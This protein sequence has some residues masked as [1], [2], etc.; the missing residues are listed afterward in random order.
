MNPQPAGEAI[1]TDG[2]AVTSP[3]SSWNHDRCGRCG[4]TFRRG[5]A[6]VVTVRPRLVVVHTDPWLACGGDSDAHGSPDHD[7]AGFAAGLLN[8][9]PPAGGIPV[10]RLAANDWRVATPDRVDPPRCLYCGHTFRASEHVV[11]CP[12]GPLTPKCGAAVHRD[13]AAGLS[14]WEA[15][16]PDSTLSVCPVTL[17]RVGGT[18]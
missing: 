13:P 18:Q 1:T 6:V 4:Q 9:F 7:D 10:H 8:A 5:D 3:A 16:R 15:W 17:A 11:V 12:C 2:R 14:C